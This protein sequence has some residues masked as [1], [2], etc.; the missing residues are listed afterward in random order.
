VAI[1]QDK[2]VGCRYCV[3]ACP[4]QNRVFLAK[5][6]DKGFFPGKGLTDFEKA[7]KRHYP[8]QYGTTEKCNF[9]IERIDAGQAKGLKPGVD[10]RATPACVNN[11]QARALMFGDLD[12]AGSDV[13]RLIRESAGFQLHPEYGTHPSIYYV[14][15]QRIGRANLS[16]EAQVAPKATVTGAVPERVWEYHGSP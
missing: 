5:S 7:G 15:K 4:Y 11:C 1:N 6:K 12:D 2:C 8:H 13:S 3:V 16:A 9:C 10:R 14:D